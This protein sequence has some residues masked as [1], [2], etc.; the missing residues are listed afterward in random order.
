MDE[1]TS[2]ENP[3]QQN[4]DCINIAGSYRCKCAQGYKLSPGG[5]CV[6]KWGHSREVREQD[7]ARLCFLLGLG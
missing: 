2:G 5:A 6:G 1:C 4:A 3:C 7:K